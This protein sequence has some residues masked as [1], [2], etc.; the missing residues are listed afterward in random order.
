[1]LWLIYQFENEENKIEVAGNHNYMETD[2]SINFVQWSLKSHF[3]GYPCI[4]I[5]FVQSSLKSHSLRIALHKY[6]FR[7]VVSKISFFADS[8]A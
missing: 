5:D 1:M 2:I 8:P 7:P 6:R 4:N 3:C